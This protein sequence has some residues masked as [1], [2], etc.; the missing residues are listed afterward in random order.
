VW[1]NTQAIAE[2]ARNWHDLA[3]TALAGLADGDAVVAL[4]HQLDRV[5]LARRRDAL[6]AVALI[7]AGLFLDLRGEPVVGFAEFLEEV[8]DYTQGLRQLRLTGSSKCRN[9]NGKW[10]GWT[11]RRISWASRPRCAS[12]RA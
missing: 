11:C 9:A 3:D 5:L 8:D 6:A 1:P 2:H 7:V 4:V 12:A 10:R